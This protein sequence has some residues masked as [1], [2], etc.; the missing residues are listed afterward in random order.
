MEHK[1]NPVVTADAVIVR[2]LGL[3]AYESVWQAMR[4]FT[5]QRMDTTLDEIWL[6]EHPSIFTQGQNGHQQH[7]LDPGAIPV[8]HVDRGGQITY[9]G[10]G[11]LVVYPLVN[12]QRKRL[13]VRDI[14]SILEK[15]VIQLLTEYSIT[16]TT[17]CGAPGVY[18]NTQKICSI[19]LRI[20][21]GCAFHGLA[22]NV[23][24]DLQPFTRIHPCGFSGL[25]MT[26]IADFNQP[27]D[28]AG[29]GQRLLKYLIKNLRY[30]T[31]C[32]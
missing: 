13:N 19:G 26:Q 4:D 20:R 9:H 5:Q 12:I 3:C 28:I 17:Q 2:S 32:N 30:T 14:V 1:L 29:T 6:L 11:Q 16:A 10:P 21:R 22:L 7:I 27:D 8:I 31:V 23:D 15:S 18:V 25:T 24:M